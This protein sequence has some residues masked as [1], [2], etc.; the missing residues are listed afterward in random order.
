MALGRA[1]KSCCA[2]FSYVM[3]IFYC[4]W[5]YSAGVILGPGE[6][7]TRC[8]T[9]VFWRILLSVLGLQSEQFVVAQMVEASDWD[10]SRV[11]LFCF[12]FSWADHWGTPKVTGRFL[13]P[14]WPCSA[15][16]PPRRDRSIGWFCCCIPELHCCHHDPM[17]SGWI[18]QYI[19][20]A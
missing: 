9:S 8:S 17:E 13:C 7:E 18:H 16:G 10:G 6:Q 5:H 11:S 4:L 19:Y 3:I 12:C 15:L 1:L 2:S 20:K 14:I